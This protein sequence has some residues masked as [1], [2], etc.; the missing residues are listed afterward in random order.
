M[1]HEDLRTPEQKFD[2]MLAEGMKLMEIAN[3]L[4]WTYLQ[5][6]NRYMRICLDLGEKPDAE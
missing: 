2:D 5:A 4:G 3:R 1:K 6:R